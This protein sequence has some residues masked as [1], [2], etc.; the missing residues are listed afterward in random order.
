M[1]HEKKLNVLLVEDD[2]IDA[3][4]IRQ[5]FAMN[6]M[7]K[8]FFVAANGLEALDLLNFKDSQPSPIPYHRRLILLDLTMPQM[9]GIEFLQTLRNDSQLKSIPVV[10]L[11]DA[12]DD[13]KLIESY[14]LNVAGYLIKPVNFEKFLETITTLSD[15]WTRCE[16]V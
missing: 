4:N 15:Y 2:L 12:K 13:Q 9:N 7:T 16:M 11:T 14:Q 5:I 8:T 1:M 6:N 10:V 3:T